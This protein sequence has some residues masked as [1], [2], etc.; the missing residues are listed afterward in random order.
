M[1]LPSII[2]FAHFGVVVAIA[3]LILFSR[4][5]LIS[6]KL[7]FSLL[8]LFGTI[9]ISAIYNQAGLINLFLDFLLLSQPILFL[10]IFNNKIWTKEHLNKFRRFLLIFVLINAAFAFFQFLVLGLRIDG[11]KGVFI[12][13]GAGHHVAGAI[14]LSSCIYFVRSIR[15]LPLKIGFI[16]VQLLVTVVVDNKQS[17]A[18][19]LVSFLVLMLLNLYRFKKILFLLVTIMFFTGSV[20]LM[21]I[22][23]FPQLQHW[24]HLEKI[25]EG[26]T[27]KFFVFDI[28]HHYH[29]SI[30]N[31]LFGLGPGHTVGRLAQMLPDYYGILYPIGAT[32]SP[33]F[34]VV[35]YTQQSNWI[36]NSATGSSMWSLL[37]SWAGVYGDLGVFGVLVY[38]SIWIIVYRLL[39]RNDRS[40]FL[41][42]TIIVHGAVFQWMEEP[43]YMLFGVSLIGLMFQEDL[44][45]RKQFDNI[46]YKRNK[47]GRVS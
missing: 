24:A 5:T 46:E 32:I 43:A 16:I 37:F 45:I 23:I 36:T 17:L 15:P 10:Y 2:N 25:K 7:L 9:S 22:T 40:K 12:D 1:G 19:F 38:L 20:Y 14:A 3:F 26:L 4:Q 29:I 27:A 8:I 41:W 30:L 21:A 6:V 31:V 42:I 35:W 33:V 47:M 34:D 39:C 44:R 11:V 18:V 13:M 28:I